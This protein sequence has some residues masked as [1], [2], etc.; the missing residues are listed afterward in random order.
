MYVLSL[1]KAWRM[2]TICGILEVV[3]VKDL[4]GLQLGCA[5]MRVCCQSAGKESV[6]VRQSNIWH[7]LTLRRA[8][9]LKLASRFLYRE[10]ENEP[11]WAQASNR[12]EGRQS[13]LSN[14]VINILRI[15]IN[16]RILNLPRKNK[17]SPARIRQFPIDTEDHPGILNCLIASHRPKARLR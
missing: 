4:L 11:K 17:P 9:L 12:V 14:I 5:W 13:W 2:H 6:Q 8:E 3:R 1:I 10:V 7:Y 15:E 16:D